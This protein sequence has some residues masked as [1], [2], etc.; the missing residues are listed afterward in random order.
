ML[1]PAQLAQV[2]LVLALAAATVTSI[3][4][5]PSPMVTIGASSIHMPFTMNLQALSQLGSSM[6]TVKWHP[7]AQHV[8][9]RSSAFLGS[10]RSLRFL[11]S[12][13]ASSCIPGQLAL[14]TPHP[15]V[16]GGAVGSTTMMISVFSVG[17]HVAEP[18]IM[19]V[20][21][22]VYSIPGLLTV[23]LWLVQLAQVTL[24][25]S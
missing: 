19:M 5:R 17:P 11:V 21:A 7:P 9:R 15:G 24:A 12:R 8:A 4:A 6:N 23:M 3:L 13:R 25:L 1:W 22:T 20:C 16:G 14:C 2:T 18:Y 10:L